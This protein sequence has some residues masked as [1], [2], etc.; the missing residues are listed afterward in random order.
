MPNKLLSLVIP[1]YFNAESLPPLFAELEAVEQQLRNRNL[2]LELIFVNDG[3][4][5]GSLQ[6]LLKIKSKRPATKVI[7]LSRNFG[8]IAATKTGFGFVT[9]DAFGIL[10]A[11]LQDPPQ[12]IIEMADHWL[13]GHKFVISVRASREDPWFSQLLS[14]LYYRLV[15]L[16]VVPG[17]PAGGYD[18]MLMDKSMLRHLVNSTKHTNVALYA[19][20][21]GFNPV[22]L[23]YVRRRR[24]HGKS[25]F[26]LRKRLKFMVDTISG[27]SATPIRVMS[28]FG[29][30]VALLSF[31]YGTNIVI[32]ALLGNFDIRG[33]ATLV[34]LISFFSGLILFMLGVLGEYLWRV[35]AA[36]NNVPEAV[37]DEMFL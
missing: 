35:F 17:Y 14:C 10:A 32:N 13:T 31:I 8:V 27:F 23:Y 15:D 29:I 1:V 26:T 33:F 24:E 20:W 19:F 9:G 7:T 22:I 12:Q 16:L 21:L 37:V 3:S 36:V 11:D 30:V 34:A 4:G 5:D 2:D 18:L 25:R 6:E 28:V